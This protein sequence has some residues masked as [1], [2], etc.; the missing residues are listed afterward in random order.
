MHTTGL[1]K[2]RRDDPRLQTERGKLA[3]PVVR[4]GAGLHGDHAA[5]RQAHAPL[6]ELGTR[7]RLVR[8]HAA[9]RID[10]VHLDDVLGQID[11]YPNR[12]FSDNLVHGTSPFIGCR[13]MTLNTTNL[14]A[15]SPLPEGGKSLRIPIE[16][17]STG[18]PRLA[19]ISFWAK[20]GPPV[21]AAQ[22][23]R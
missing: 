6:K 14:G 10:A 17:T 1:D 4:T 8:E 16:R 11:P 18:R 20:R 21:P 13:L 23:E 22:L 19:L 9:C 7:D 15:S 12:A 5:G 3:C 2:L